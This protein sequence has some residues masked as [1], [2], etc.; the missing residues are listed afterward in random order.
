M[1][2]NRARHWAPLTLVAV[3]ALA[4]ASPAAGQVSIND[5]ANAGEI[6]V[7]IN[8]SQV[9]RSDPRRRETFPGLI[10]ASIARPSRVCRRPG[11][12][13]ALADEAGDRRG[14][15]RSSRRPSAR[16]SR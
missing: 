4:L 6:A 5:E 16:R 8:K 7:P 15:Q 3:L 11:S 2:N 12:R 10:K 13:Y 9:I 1:P 14:R